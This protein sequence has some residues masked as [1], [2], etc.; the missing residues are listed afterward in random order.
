[1]QVKRSRIVLLRFFT[2]FECVGTETW[3]PTIRYLFQLQS[4][5]ESTLRIKDIWTVDSPNQGEAAILNE[6]ILKEKYSD[7][8]ESLGFVQNTR[9]MAFAGQ[10]GYYG[11]ALSRVLSSGLIDYE[12]SKLVGIGHS[13]GCGALQVIVHLSAIDSSDP[14]TYSIAAIPK[15]VPIPYH[16]LILVEPGLV[17]RSVGD[18]L[19]QISQTMIPRIMARKDVWATK[20]EAINWMKSHH[21]RKAWHPEV[22]EA[23]FVR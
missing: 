16:A 9:H 6:Q 1:M 13:A 15:T 11:Q 17:H 3:I 5:P 20:E 19:R 2:I 4:E 21:P 12:G 14:R 10:L 23:I 8:C 18:A 22:M 7:I